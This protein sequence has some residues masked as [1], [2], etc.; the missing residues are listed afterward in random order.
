MF[1]A[2]ARDHYGP[3]SSHDFHAMNPKTV[4]WSHWRKSLSQDAQAA[5]YKA[6]GGFARGA[7]SAEA[8]FGTG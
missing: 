8:G 2:D 3:L 7:A 5:T 6:E 4:V 1:E